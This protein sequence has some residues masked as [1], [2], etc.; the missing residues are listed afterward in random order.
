MN[1]SLILKTLECWVFPVIFIMVCAMGFS[2]SAS[3]NRLSEEH[4]ILLHGLARSSSSMNKMEKHLKKE[5]YTVF[6]VGY[7]SRKKEIKVLSD[8]AISNT[9]LKCR[10]NNARKIHFVTHSMGGILVR[11]YLKDHELKELGRVVMLSPPNK[12]SEVVDKLKENPAFK[13]VNGPAGQELG[14]DEKSMPQRLGKVT[15]DLGVITGD[16]SINLILSLLIPGDDDGKVSIERA[17]IEGMN[18]FLVIHATHPFIMKNNKAIL[19]TIHF[20]KY[21]KFQRIAKPAKQS[22]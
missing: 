11:Y 4:V 17:K 21:G 20:L 7:E 19:Q 12:G 6:N 14:T 8:T 3:E 18:D 15:F 10:Q 22:E 5:G 9:V 13:W 16:R 1:I 2:L